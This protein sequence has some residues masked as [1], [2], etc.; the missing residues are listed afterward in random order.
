MEGKMLIECPKCKKARV[1]VLDSKCLRCGFP[2][3]DL[4]LECFGC[5][6]K[7]CTFPEMMAKDDEV[8]RYVCWC[9][10]GN[11]CFWRK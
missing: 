3:R 8:A 4:F 9:R 2:L 11:A 1:S 10:N 6:G 7:I 5:R